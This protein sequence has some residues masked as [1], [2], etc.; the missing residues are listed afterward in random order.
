MSKVL[1]QV[2]DVV[3]VVSGDGVVQAAGVKITRV[4]DQRR[5]EAQFYGVEGTTTSQPEDRIV[6][7]SMGTHALRYAADGWYMFP[8][9][10]R[11]KIPHKDFKWKELASIDPNTIRNWWRESP[12]GN[13]ACACGP[14]GLL[15][16]DL[17][18]R[19]NK[20]GPDVWHNLKIEHVF[21][22]DKTPMSLT[23]Q[24]GQHVFYDQGNLGLKNTTSRP[25]KG[26]GE[27]IDTR[28]VGGYVLL[29]PSVGPNGKP[30]AWEVSAH[31]YDVAPRPIPQTL[32]DLLNASNGDHDHTQ[33]IVGDILKNWRNDTLISLAGTMRYRGF[34]EDEILAALI[35]TNRNRCKPPLGQADV[36]RVA[37]SAGGYEPTV[38]IGDLGLE[39]IDV[40]ASPKKAWDW[41]GVKEACRP[42]EPREYIVTGLLPVPSVSTFFGTPGALK[43][44]I[45]QD[46]ALCVAKGQPWLGGLP[47]ENVT[48]FVC[49]SSPVLWTDVDNGLDRLER[50]FAALVKGLDVSEDAPLWYVSFPLPP[51]VASNK[52]A[53][54]EIL[55][56]VREV[57]A[58]L[59][60]FDNLGTVSGGADENSSEMVGVMSGLRLIAEEGNCAVVVIHHSN[61]GDATRLGNRLR[62]H[63]SIEGALDLALMIER[64]GD[65]DTIN[66]RSTKTRDI[67][68]QPFAAVWTYKQ[69]AE[70][71][72]VEGRFF[73]LGRPDG[74][75]MS[76]Q[77]QAELCIMADMADGMSQ[78]KIVQMVKVN[79]NVGRNTTLAAIRRLVSQ[80][81]IEGNLASDKK[82]MVYERLLPV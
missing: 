34:E 58:K 52:K 45:A 26:L 61:K 35:V 24:G 2:G 10:E 29:P 9:P 81:L 63:S 11:C 53:R 21:S 82:T 40:R 28:G 3:D 49:K 70:G 75:A 79:A 12:N 19:E 38:P 7:G 56:M 74:G 33:P 42:K 23:P 8:L 48:G 46:M 54:E 30:Y 50:R 17:D 60:V 15:V 14:S 59:V 13:I 80:G 65:E 25:G 1:W 6:P 57:G 51:F 20:D 37:H 31:P 27:G 66:I 4:Q 73:G 64:E 16:S 77:E 55:L 68:V 5:G 43:T 69:D 78:S 44:M 36:E 41:Q 67:P 62:G 76:K 72:L 18:V 22:D 47:G 71:D 39:G 32:V